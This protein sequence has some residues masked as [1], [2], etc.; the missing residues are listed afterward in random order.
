MMVD[1]EKLIL[2]GLEEPPIKGR[3][4][5][6]PEILRI[7]RSKLRDETQS[8]NPSDN[9]RKRNSSRENSLESLL[10]AGIPME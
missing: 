3:N 5:T 8:S 9:K 10:E 1:Y 6:N 2:D 4:N 7:S